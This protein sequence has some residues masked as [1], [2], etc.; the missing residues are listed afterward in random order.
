MIRWMLNRKMGFEDDLKISVGK[1]KH[2]Q[3]GF[4][5]ALIPK[6]KIGFG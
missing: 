4:D 1:Q 3:D 6:I 2:Q 5:G